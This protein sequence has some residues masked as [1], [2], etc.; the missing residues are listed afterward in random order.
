MLYTPLLPEAASG[1]LEPR[2]VVVPLR[3]M[4][5]H[6]EL[7]LGRATAVD[8]EART[9]RSRRDERLVDRPLGASSCVALGASSRTL[10]V[11]GLTEHGALLQV[12]RRRDPPPQPRPAPARGGR[13][14]ARRRGRARRAADL[15]LRRRGLRGRRGARGAVRP[16]PRRAPLLPAAA[17][18]PAAL[19]ARRRRAE[20]PPR[21]PDAGSAS[22][23]PRAERARH[24]DPRR[25]DARRRSPREAAS[26]S[27]GDADPDEHARLD[28][29][30]HAR[31]PL[32]A[33]LGL[34][35]DERG[36]VEVDEM[37]RVGATSTSGRSATA[38]ACR[39][40]DAGPARPADV[41]A[42][43]A[44]GAAPGEEPAGRP[45]AV[46]LPDARPGGDARPLQGDRRRARPAPARLPRLVGDAD[47]PPVPA[48]A[49]SR[50][51]SASSPTGRRR[52]SSAATSP[53]S[54]CSATPRDCGER[55]RARVPPPSS[56]RPAPERDA[57]RP[58]YGTRPLSAT[59]CRHVWDLNFL[60]VRGAAIA[61]ARRARDRG[62][63]ADGRRSDHRR[64]VMDDE[65]LDGLASSAEFPVHGSRPSTRHLRDGASTPAR[66]G[67]ATPA[68]SRSLRADASSSRSW[69]ALDRRR[70]LRRSASDAVDRSGRARRA[71]SRAARGR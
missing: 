3:V 33:E 70:W 5:P 30:R 34:P 10:P 11:P 16:R 13:R 48:A 59:S 68:C 67:S 55:E 36:R 45:A 7:L 57:S 40:G 29:R 1:T 23:P 53:S 54:A 32:L 65:A 12:A 61:G 66:G 27:D 24:R 17:R 25:H 8:L 52:C 35:L 56:R 9:A 18:R 51:S 43:A 22:T 15:R 21:D 41:P 69:A 44:P 62:R 64:V 50:G 2:H 14:G 19:G 71:T 49:R 6:A 58:Q 39:T 63:A 28:G 4:C 38:R 60:R 37:L 20:D 26:L 31:N 46:R 47:V 42:R